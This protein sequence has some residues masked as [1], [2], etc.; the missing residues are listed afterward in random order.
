MYE[1]IGVSI[2]TGEA[3]DWLDNSTGQ[4][5]STTDEQEAREMVFKLNTTFRTHANYYLR[6]SFG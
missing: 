5:W 3:F 6:R 1:I 4:P 2:R